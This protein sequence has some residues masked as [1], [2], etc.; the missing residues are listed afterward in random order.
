MHIS[1]RASTLVA[2]AGL[3]GIVL[4]VGYIADTSKRADAVYAAAPAEV[5]EYR[6]LNRRIGHLQDE[7]YRLNLSPND[8]LYHPARLREAQRLYGAY[9][10]LQQH[11][12]ELE[13]HPAVAAAQEKVHTIFFP[14]TYYY[15]SGSIFSTFV[16]VGGLGMRKKKKSALNSSVPGSRSP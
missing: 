15:L 10:T 16:F 6:D 3:T 1:P 9:K 8:V 11:Q 12:Q 2:A 13:S 5:R 7:S 4:S 14:A